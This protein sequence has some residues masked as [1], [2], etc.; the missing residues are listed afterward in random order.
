MESK[1]ALQNYVLDL[2]SLLME[3]RKLFLGVLIRS[4]LDLYV[5]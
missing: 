5:S 2:G 1:D 4:L 3:G